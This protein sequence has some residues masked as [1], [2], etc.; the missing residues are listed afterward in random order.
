MAVSPENEK[1][2]KLFKKKGRE[3][4]RKGGKSALCFVDASF[5]ADC[6]ALE[7]MRESTNVHTIIV[8]TECVSIWCF[9]HLWQSSMHV[10]VVFEGGKAL[11]IN[12]VCVQFYATATLHI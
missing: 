10:I 2:L 12:C 4:K 8:I 11:L 6:S 7:N 9:Y 3:R 5:Y 1:Q